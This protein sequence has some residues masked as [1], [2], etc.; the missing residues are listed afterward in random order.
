MGSIKAFIVA[1][2]LAAV[3]P[4][5]AAAAD[6]LPPPPPPPVEPIVAAPFSGWYLRGDVGV[7][8]ASI[9]DLRNSFDS[10]FTVV[11]DQFD[12]KSLGDS[13]FA[14]V[15]VGYQFN[16]WFHADVTSEYRTA[17][18]YHT[19]ESAIFTCGVVGV[20]RCHDNYT[21]SVSSAVFLAN[22]YVDLGTWWG[23]TPFIG[24]GVGVADNFFQGLTDMG[25]AGGFGFAQNHSSLNFAWAAMAGIGYAITPNLRL[26]IGYRHLDMGTA[27]SGPVICQNTPAC[28]HEVQRFALASNDIRLGMRWIFAEVPPAPPPPVIA[29]Y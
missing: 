19:I 17:G 9:S 7:G 6:L 13:A 3:A 10:N 21:G 8:V 5:V 27:V 12:S 26:E 1:I 28:G 18:A 24:A 22:G 29:K 20:T 25:E 15:G 14:G 23:F 4:G 11:G 16:N 2:G